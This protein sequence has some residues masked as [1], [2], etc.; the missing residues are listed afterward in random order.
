MRHSLW[1]QDSLK[2]LND[3]LFG[4]MDGEVEALQQRKTMYDEERRLS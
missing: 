3:V 1:E 4:Y 2:A